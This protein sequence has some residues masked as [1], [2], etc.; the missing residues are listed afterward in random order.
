MG[1]ASANKGIEIP[2]EEEILSLWRKIPEEGQ[3]ELLRSMHN[4]ACKAKRQTVDEILG[5]AYGEENVGVDHY[6]ARVAAHKYQEDFFDRVKMAMY[7]VSTVEVLADGRGTYVYYDYNRRRERWL[8]GE[9]WFPHMEEVADLLELSDDAVLDLECLFHFYFVPMAEK[10]LGKSMEDIR[11]RWRQLLGCGQAK[12]EEEC[13]FE[14]GRVKDLA[15]LLMR[16]RWQERG[17][18][19]KN[20]YY[21]WSSDYREHPWK[22]ILESEK[23]DA[24]EQRIMKDWP[25]EGRRADK[26]ELWHSL[27]PTFQAKERREK[28]LKAF[29]LLEKRE[30]YETVMEAT[31]LSFEE[32]LVLD[33]FAWRGEARA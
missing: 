33:C 28:V 31:A 18:G 30:P 6:Y 10:V 27:Y 5:M 32:I 7:Y 8:R 4:L 17:R 16:Q 26:M 3:E 14:A 20:C 12:A 13:A 22:G 1:D 23:R 21:N 29:S 19:K 15:R 25:R 9:N 24:A 11:E 2:A